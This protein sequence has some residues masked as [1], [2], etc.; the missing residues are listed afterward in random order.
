MKLILLAACCTLSIWASTAHARIG[1]SAA[2]CRAR[3]GAPVST[4]VIGAAAENRTSMVYHKN[5]IEVVTTH[6]S[7]KCACL[8][9]KRLDGGA[10][11]PTQI[12]TILAANAPGKWTRLDSRQGMTWVTSDKKVQAK[13]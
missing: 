3:Y 13:G 7:G 5:G 1:E 12:E 6:D 2:Q 11:S 9:L 10:L 8:T 4:E